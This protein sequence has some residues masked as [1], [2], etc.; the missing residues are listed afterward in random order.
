MVTDW[1][2]HFVQ[3][4]IDINILGV[5]ELEPM[6]LTPPRLVIDTSN[7]FKYAEGFKEYLAK[8]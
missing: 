7:P 1:V 3:L 4:A 8:Q 2:G 6:P 5:M